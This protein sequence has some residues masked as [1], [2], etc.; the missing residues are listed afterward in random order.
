MR[1]ALHRWFTNPLAALLALVTAGSAPAEAPLWH[2]PP[3]PLAG[4]PVAAMTATV[5]PAISTF[6][7][8]TTQAADHPAGPPA[9]AI[10]H[11]PNQ[12]G[13]VEP[14]LP[15]PAD[16]PAPPWQPGDPPPGEPP[17]D[18]AAGPPEVLP[19]LER[20]GNCVLTG[21]V[22]D[23]ATVDPVAGAV[24]DLPEL[25]RTAES[26]AQGKFQIGG[27]PAGTFRLEATKLGYSTG[28]ATV[29]T[30]PE[31][32]ATISV[33]LRLRPTGGE[34]D[35]YVLEEE[36][37]I[38]EYQEETGT[39]FDL[40]L[41]LA[42]K[43]AAGI[44]RDDF[45]KSVVSDAG[46]AI[47][48]IS[49][50]NIVD[51]KY[52]VVRGLADRYITTTFN[53]A[54]IASADPSRKA[55]QLDLF[56]TNVI[57]SIGVDKTYRPQLAGDF[58]GGAIDIVTRAFPEERILDFKFKIDYNDGLEDEIYVHP[59][60]S[61]GFWGD[62]GEPMPP[63]LEVF[64]PDGSTAGFLDRTVAT[65]EEL[66]PRWRELH[67]S[68][69][70]KPVQ[71]DAEFGYSYGLT[72]GETFKFDNGMRLG[73]VLSGG[74][75]SGDSS[76]TSPVT[77]PV[78][79]YLRDNYTR[80]IDWV[81]FG[82]AA[83][84][85][86]EH[87]QVK[88][89]YFKRR[90]AQDEVQLSSRIIDGEENLNYGFHMPNR[91]VGAAGR[92]NDYVTDFRYFGTAWDILPLSRDL[93]ITQFQGRHGFSDRGPRLDWSVTDSSS[94]ESRPHSTH[95]EFGTLDFSSQA[96]AGVIAES[97]AL[98]DQQAV[99]WADGLLGLPDPESYTWETI[100]QPM[101][102]AGR[103]TTYDRFATRTAVIPDD[104]RAPVETLVHGRYSG[105]VPGKQRSS[106]RTEET[107]EDSFHS[108]ISATVPFYFSDDSEDRFEFGAGAA[109]LRKTRTTTARQYD[110]FIQ[111]NG[112]D[113]GY[114]G[115]AS[116]NGPGGRGEQIASDPTLITDDFTGNTRTGPFYLN[117]LTDNG[118][119]NIETQLDQ[120]AWFLAGDLKL[121][122]FFLN[123][124]VR[125]EKEEYKI[126]IEGAPLS[127]FT[128]EQ[129]EG[130]GWENRDPEEAWLPAVLGGVTTFDKRVDWLAGW[131]RTVARPT[132]WEFIPSQTYDQANGVGRRGNNRLN[133]TEVTNFDFAVTYR[134][135]ERITLRTSLFHKDLVNPL[136]NFFDNGVLVYAD[137]YVAD[138][139]SVTPFTATIDGIE[140]EA[141]IS[142]LGPFSVKGNFTYIDAVLDYTF[143]TGGRASAVSS[144]LPYQPETIFNL[145]LGYQY[146]PWDL[147]A[148]LIY[149]LTSS[150]PTVLK[151]IPEDNEIR[152]DSLSTLD[153]VVAKTISDEHC[154]W[155]F[156]GGVKNLLN[157]KDTLFY[158]D[159][160]FYEDKIGR[161]FF[162]EV[163][164]S[165]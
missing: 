134:P 106:R 102:D 151:R 67:D 131:S 109:K 88:A 155:T 130:N 52:A 46:E 57:E 53:G 85:L 24:I 164:A 4:P 159:D 26:D 162:L 21:E 71:D 160:V 35:E 74:Y 117:A 2:E 127:A 149:N 15:P 68:T 147:T 110:L 163:E 146:E 114:P 97:D 165:F 50:A 132:F 51:G 94:I 33:G 42:P 66:Q 80:G 157:A 83:L 86:N 112:F 63:S 98:R 82:S 38:G 128:D 44:S 23:S 90:S 22:Y 37:V 64:N 27:L 142:D 18:Q 75:S 72:Y 108:Q 129:I 29:T 56:P 135:N 9:P 107:A 45:K 139:G 122:N 31:Q 70:L 95:F 92:N 96:L 36:V 39:G 25:G 49:G 158:G 81:G 104:S 100:E 40:Q 32:P 8:A 141:E 123:G 118:L 60:R 143:V 78:R 55:V 124:G 47:A 87:N 152:R 79:T 73:V 136:V 125:Y 5:L 12:A 11:D 119:E 144:Q 120:Q 65:P 93:E 30:T 89:T 10:P 16:P 137:S 3:L 13:P 41:V 148:N 113:S 115:N 62:L 1:T 6:P 156:R 7:L 105:S 153:L 14:L 121:G 59:D 28:E 101:R 138:D 61:I 150:Y 161:T 99:V 140:F 111:S 19:A 103:G 54:Q 34:G 145:N 58:G 154:E 69:T 20:T 43:L 126:D 77:N 116:F 76:N 91:G 133:P 48:K 17:L 84:E